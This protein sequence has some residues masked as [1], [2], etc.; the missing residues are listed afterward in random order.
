M[1]FVRKAGGW[2]DRQSDH[3]NR[4][5]LT[6]IADPTDIKTY[7]ITRAEG[8]VSVE[9]S[10]MNASAMEDLEDRIEDMNDSLVGSPVTVTLEA[11]DWNSTTHLINVPLLGVTATSN[12]DIF[13]L[14]ATSSANIQ[15]NQALQNAN[16]MDYGQSTGSITLYA[17]TVP[18]TDLQIRVIV[19]S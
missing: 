1:S 16:I 10:A 9:G 19:R 2:Q 8:N 11:S 12:Q 4:R 3:P 14:P 6:N 15:N 17:V 7:D 13:G 5:T 18:S